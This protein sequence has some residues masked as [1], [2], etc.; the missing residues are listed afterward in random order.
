MLLKNILAQVPPDPVQREQW[1]QE[2]FMMVR[3]KPRVEVRGL[4]GDPVVWRFMD[5]PKLFDLLTKS[6]LLIPQL[7]AA[8][9]W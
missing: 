2:Q 5:L 1:F 9:G 6:R 8:D 3:F 7:R 4:S